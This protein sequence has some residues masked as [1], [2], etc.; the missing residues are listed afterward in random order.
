[1]REALLKIIIIIISFL[2]VAVLCAVIS[3]N[4]TSNET[5]GIIIIWVL[6]AIMIVSVFK[7]L[8]REL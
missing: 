5:L 3:T 7:V 8:W 1:M 4:V 6:G 2:V